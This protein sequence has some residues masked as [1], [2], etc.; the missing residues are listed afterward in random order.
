MEILLEFV[1]NILYYD[2]ELNHMMMCDFANHI[3]RINEE[4]QVFNENLDSR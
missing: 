4:L 2:G 3:F 1:V